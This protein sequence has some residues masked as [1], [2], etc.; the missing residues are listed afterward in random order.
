MKRFAAVVV[1]AAVMLAGCRH[2]AAPVVLP[3]N[4]TAPVSLEKVPEPMNPPLVQSLPLQPAPLPDV[5]P[6]AKKV[7]K[8]RKKVVAPPVMV[9]PVQVASAGPPTGESVIG[10]LTPG[11]EG[12]PERQRVAAEMIA[13]L[14]K[15]LANLSA[16]AGK[17]K[18]QVERV[19]YFEQQARAALKARGFG[20]GG[21]AGYEGE[22]AAG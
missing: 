19:R 21:D 20:W 5:T 8:F 3:V 11:G 16:T 13:T 4:V 10:A 2:K 14:E 12:S 22:A 6:V 9:A 15:R 7:K 18:E 17:Q 1:G